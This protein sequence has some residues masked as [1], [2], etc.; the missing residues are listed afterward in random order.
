MYGASGSG[1]HPGKGGYSCGIL[2]LLEPITLYLYIGGEGKYNPN[3]D[4][5][6]TCIDGGW[7]GGGKACS[8]GYQCSGGGGTDIRLDKNNLY[9]NRIIV[10]GGGGGDG[11]G[12]GG[13]K[14]EKYHGG[15]GSGIIG[16][17]LMVIQGQVIKYLANFIQMEVLKKKVELV[18]NM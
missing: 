16:E 10:A 9:S 2:H 12:N 14:T 13:E 18:L 11:N 3:N 8:C 17:F 7:N 4:E 6:T 5:Y 15:D 1:E